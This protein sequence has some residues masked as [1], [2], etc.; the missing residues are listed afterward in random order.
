MI[1]LLLFEVMGRVHRTNDCVIQKL[2][3]EQSSHLDIK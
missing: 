3:L 2:L 1:S